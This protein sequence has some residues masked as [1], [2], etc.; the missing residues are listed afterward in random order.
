LREMFLE[1]VIFGKVRVTKNVDGNF[2][3]LKQIW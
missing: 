2:N 3:H 1:E